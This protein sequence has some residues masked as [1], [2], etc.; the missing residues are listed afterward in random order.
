MCVLCHCVCVCMCVLCHCVCVCVCVF[1]CVWRAYAF[2]CV[3]VYATQFFIQDTKSSNGTFVNESRL[4]PSGEE[5]AG[6]AQVKGHGA[7]RRECERR[8]ER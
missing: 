5:R 7:I 2:A 3:C 1:V 8:E 4:S 6:R